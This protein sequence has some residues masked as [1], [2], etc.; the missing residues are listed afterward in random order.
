MKR[1]RRSA[2]EE[3][4]QTD[5]PAPRRRRGATPS[6]RATGSGLAAFEEQEAKK[7]E[8]RNELRKKGLDRV[9]RYFLEPGDNREVIFLD[10]SVDKGCG[11]YEHTVKL[12]AKKW[13]NFACLTETMNCP[14]CATNQSAW[15]VYYSVLV[16]EDYQNKKTG[17]WLNG[18]K[19]LGIK[20]SQWTQFKKLMEIAQKENDGSLRGVSMIL[21]REEGSKSARIG[22][23]VEYED[24]GKRYDILSEEE[25]EEY[26]NEEYKSENTGQVVREAGVDIEAFDYSLAI[27]EYTIEELERFTGVSAGPRAGS[28]KEVAD[29]WA[30]EEEEEEGSRPMRRRRRGAA[31][32]KAKEEAAAPPR[33][34]RRAKDEEEEDGEE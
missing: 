32:V 15:I 20:Y 29:R 2:P 7:Q 25:L 11:L 30:E 5:K 21:Q 34:G 13:G 18:R 10:E 1:S 17:E 28:P 22:V 8:T 26:S 16:L 6:A 9:F 14:L 33:R 31:N 4:A 23:P 27:P 19:L 24:T 12:G 3:E